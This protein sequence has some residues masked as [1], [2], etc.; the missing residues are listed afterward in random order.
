METTKPMTGSPRPSARPWSAAPVALAPV[1]VALGHVAPTGSQQGT[2]LPALSPS[3]SM[4]ATT[5]VVTPLITDVRPVQG[6][7]ARG[8][9]V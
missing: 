2:G 1:P 6:V 5:S 9:P 8:A 4:S 3:L 7:P